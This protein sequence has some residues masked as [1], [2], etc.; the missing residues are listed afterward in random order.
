[1]IDQFAFDFTFFRGRVALASVLK[2]MGIGRGDEVALQAYTCVA[3]PEG[4]MAS[5]ARPI[6]VD[7]E[8]GG[9]TMSPASLEE[10]ITERT[11]AIVVQHTF[12][13]PANMTEIMRIAQNHGLPVIEDCAHTYWSEHDGRRVGTFGAAAYYSLEWAKPLVLGVG[14]GLV[15]NDPSLNPAISAIHASL[16]QPS[17]ARDARLRLQYIAFTSLYGP[18]RFWAIKKTYAALSSAGVAE[19]SFNDMER[20]PASDFGL[21]LAPSV[22]ARLRRKLPGFRADWGRNKSIVDAYLRGLAGCS[23]V[24]QIAA[25]DVDRIMFARLP[26][27]AADKP[28]MLSVAQDIGFELSDWFE[29]AVDP[30]QGAGF[31]SVGYVPGSCP[32]AETSA[33]H[34]VSL[35]C[36]DKVSPAMAE[37]AGRQFA[38][39]LSA[40]AA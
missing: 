14:G 28:R 17:A 23:G 20:E 32:N 36:N 12:G 4:V 10:R 7:V 11:R 16:S 30:L 24:Q 9:V 35:P 8:A 18:T 5:G 1:M 3:V 15:V 25:P 27:W 22:E 37:R 21:T 6:Y 13:Y 39:M 26:L 38:S 33:E 40:E 34:I 2:A 31:A 29:S 19:K